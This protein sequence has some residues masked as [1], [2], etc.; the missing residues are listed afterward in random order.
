MRPAIANFRVFDLNLFGE[1]PKTAREARALPRFAA[2]PSRGELVGP[3][4]VSQRS[5]CSGGLKARPRTDES[6]LRYG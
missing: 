6:V 1:A 2:K 3:A 4:H 5:V